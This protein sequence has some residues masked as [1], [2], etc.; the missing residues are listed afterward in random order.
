M[1]SRLR[2]LIRARQAPRT[3]G[4]PQ[5][6]AQIISDRGTRVIL[7]FAPVEADL[8]GDA[9]AWSQSART[10]LK[11][12][13]LSGGG[14]LK[15]WSGTLM[16][17]NPDY[18][19]SV[20]HLVD[21]IRG[22][23]ATGDAI[24]FYCGGPERGRW[25][26]TSCPVHV[27]LRVPGSNDAARATVSLVLTEVSDLDAH[28][29]PTSG[30]AAPPAPW[31]PYAVAVTPRQRSYR[32]RSGDTLWSIA[33]KVY[34]EPNRWHQIADANNIRNPRRLRVGQVLIIP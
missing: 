21:A 33:A 18:R 24:Q 13:L 32:V 29:S 8:D 28:V 3:Q 14:Q 34:G 17:A 12:L 9:V 15:T 5:R 4:V 1:A 6:K 27:I 26:I 11:P 25:R 20:Q 2:L 16:L 31:S 7:P 30:R 22:I 10:G 23:A 19:Q